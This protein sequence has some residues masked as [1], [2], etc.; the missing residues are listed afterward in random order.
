MN[1]RERVYYGWAVF[2]RSL[3][4][5]MVAT[6]ELRGETH[7]VNT[8]Q[9]ISEAMQLLNLEPESYLI[10]RNREIIGTQET[11]FDGD[12]VQLIPVIAGG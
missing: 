12:T 3:I 10:M 1:P 8:P 9:S 6:I 11:L 5:D 7:T 2:N 4:P